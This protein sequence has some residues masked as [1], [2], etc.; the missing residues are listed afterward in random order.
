MAF[1]L[2]LNGTAIAKETALGN[3]RQQSEVKDKWIPSE[4][5]GNT[6]HVGTI[7]VDNETEIF[8]KVVDLSTHVGF[9]NIH[10][11]ADIFFKGTIDIYKDAS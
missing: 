4:P 2:K 8:H 7:K 9:F 10:I 6:D 1:Y 11:G 5:A 3:S